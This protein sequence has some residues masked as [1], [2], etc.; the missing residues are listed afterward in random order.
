MENIYHEIIE[1]I[2][3]EGKRSAKR[4]GNI[5]DIGITKRYLTEEDLNIER[6][7]KNGK[8]YEVTKILKT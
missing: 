7:I 4:A 8:C 1:F 5:D 6:G 2:V 3:Q